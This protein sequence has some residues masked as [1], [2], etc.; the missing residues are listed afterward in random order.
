[1]LAFIGLILGGLPILFRAFKTGL[2]KT[3]KSLGLSHL[4]VFLLLFAVVVGMS[5]VRETGDSLG[6]IEISAGSLLILFFV[7]I[8]T[9]STMIIPGISGSLTLMIIGYYYSLL[10]TVTGFID[11]L[12]GL[13]LDQLIHFTIILF[14]FGLGFLAGLALISKLVDYLFTNYPSLTY[15]GILGLVL[16]SPIAILLNTNAFAR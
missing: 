14:P 2:D 11:A 8:L 9:S 13:D 10:H 12:R 16:A 1:A 7:G 3:G 6:P 15:S 4:I 5:L